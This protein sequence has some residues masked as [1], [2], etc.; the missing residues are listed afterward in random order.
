MAKPHKNKHVKRVKKPLIKQN[1]R[2]AVMIKFN[3]KDQ[4]INYMV[5]YKHLYYMLIHLIE[6]KFDCKFTD[7]WLEL[8]KGKIPH[9][10]GYIDKLI[11]FE[12]Q[13]FYI[14]PEPIEDEAWYSNYVQKEDTPFYYH[15]PPSVMTYIPDPD[16]KYV[17]EH[18][19]AKTWSEFLYLCITC[20]QKNYVEWLHTQHSKIILSL[21]QIFD[22]N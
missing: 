9:I 6:M 7:L 18:I 16:I 13:G 3:G 12:L 15:T 2:Y 11:E 4:G 14:R 21:T 17:S 1:G 22:L 8:G 10:H 19:Y 5:Q 20:G